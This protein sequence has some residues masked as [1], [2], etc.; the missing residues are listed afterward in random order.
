[1]ARTKINTEQIK[2]FLSEGDLK[3][4]REQAEKEGSSMSLIV[5]RAVKEMIAKLGTDYQGR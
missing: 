2:V 5:R 3:F 1:M 4:L